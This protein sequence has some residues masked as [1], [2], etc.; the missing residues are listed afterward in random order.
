MSPAGLAGAGHEGEGKDV[1]GGIC[2]RQ[3]RFVWEDAAAAAVAAVAPRPLPPGTGQLRALRL[4]AVRPAG[5]PVPAAWPA[6]RRRLLVGS[7]ALVAEPMGPTPTAGR[8]RGRRRSP[9]SW[10]RR[11]WSSCRTTTSTCASTRARSCRR[12]SAWSPRGIP[13]STSFTATS[14]GGG[15]RA[16]GRG[17]CRISSRG[18]GG[19]SIRRT[20]RGWCRSRCRWSAWRG[21]R[22]RT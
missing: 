2:N 20:R 3:R 22:G 16:P 21:W 13:T 19:I 9:S 15:R 8:P 6:Y 14:P 5:P 12:R 11:P 18:A 1:R 17:A 10:S 4:P 7:R